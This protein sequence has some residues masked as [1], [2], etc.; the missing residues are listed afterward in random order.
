MEALPSRDRSSTGSVLPGLFPKTVRSLNP[1]ERAF[2]RRVCAVV[3]GHLD[4]EELSVATL[5]ERLYVS[6]SAL[7]R[8]MR[9]LIGRPPTWLVMEIRLRRSAELLRSEPCSVTEVSYAVGFRDLG[10]FSRRFKTRF[11][12]SPSVFR[13]GEPDATHGQRNA[14]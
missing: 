1:E 5:A 8:R 4:E 10:H 6:R 9:S 7:H 11:G 2:L 3:E 13:R 14:T 12:V